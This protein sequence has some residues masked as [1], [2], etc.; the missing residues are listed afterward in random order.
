MIRFYAPSY[1]RADGIL[2]HRVFPDTVYCV[3]EFEVEEYEAKGVNVAKLPD[4]IRGNIARVR[5]WIKAEAEKESGA[6]VILDD[7]IKAFTYW[8]E[9]KKQLLTGERA[10]DHVQ[11]MVDL[12]ETWGASL[13]GVNPAIDKGSYREHTPFST[14]SYCSASFHGFNGCRYRYDE[15]IPL[16]EDYDICLQVLNAERIVLRFNQYGLDKDDHQ[17]E[18]GCADYRTIGIEREQFDIFQRKW[19]KKIVQEDTRSK[20]AFD[21]NPIVKVPI[22]GV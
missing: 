11:R 15:R 13:F 12:A 16:K 8:Q 18:G 19:G 3:H 14:V 6:F 9:Q 7:D 2:T 4:E 5:N 1:K 22:K 17:N 20:Q 21:I 10:L